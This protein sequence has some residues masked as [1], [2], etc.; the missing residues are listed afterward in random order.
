MTMTTTITKQE[1]ARELLARRQARERLID[2]TRYTYPQYVVDPVHE[3]LADA[4]DEVVHGSLRYLMVFAPPQHGKSE[5][6]SRRLP[7]YWLAH[8]PNEPVMLASYSGGLAARH[9]RDA[10]A[11]VESQEYQRLFPDITT[12]PS[13]RAGDLWRIL[14]HRGFML[15]GGIGGPLTGSGARLGIVDDPF[16]SWET[17]HSPT[18]RTKVRLWFEGTFYTRL[19][20]DHRLIIVMTR[21][22]EDDL[23]GYLLKKHP[24]RFEVLRLPALAESQEQRDRAHKRM[25]LSEGLDDPLGREA[26]EALAPQRFNVITLK[27]TQETV[28]Q[29]VWNAEYQGAP[30]P[31]EGNR[32][33]REWLEHYVDRCPREGVIRLRYWD[34]AGSEETGSYTAGVRLAWQESSGLLFIE[35]V[36]R[37]QWEYHERED[38]MFTTAV[39]DAE[40]F[41][42]ASAVQIWIEQEG[43]SGGKESAQRTITRLARFGVQT[44]IPRGSKDTRLEPFAIHAGNHRV[45]LVRAPWN[46]EFIE[47]MAAVPYSAIRDQADAT[48]AG[49]NLLTGGLDNIMNANVSGAYA[50]QERDQLDYRKPQ[51]ATARRPRRRQG[52]KPRPRR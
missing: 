11:I 7:A 13:S 6:V 23:A 29:M 33:K 12:D 16:A 39:A 19:W 43:G 44:D 36:I 34:K 30:T 24:G 1:A 37:G 49:F 14:G 2:F 31:P 27:E 32:I 5:L 8:Y 20:E 45:R 47:E 48:A 3:L 46:E 21:W 41:L 25:G 40:E 17:A 22:H 15:S 38:T 26:G 18:I 52:G 28:G 9:G 4:L 42:S 50:S 35:D 51:P 10:R